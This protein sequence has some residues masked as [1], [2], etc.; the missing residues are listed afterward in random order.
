MTSGVAAG[1]R[2]IGWAIVNSPQFRPVE[3]ELGFIVE[4]VVLA[5][6]SGTASVCFSVMDGKIETAYRPFQVDRRSVVH[7]YYYY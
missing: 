7:F 1:G 6:C 3:G 4:T 5:H 2:G